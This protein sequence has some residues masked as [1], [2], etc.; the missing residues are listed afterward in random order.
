M[1]KHDM[2]VTTLPDALE[3]HYKDRIR[4]LEIQLSRATTELED[5]KCTITNLRTMLATNEAKIQEYRERI[6][7]VIMAAGK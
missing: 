5:A 4:E 3:K 1:G 2:A 7:D 6:V